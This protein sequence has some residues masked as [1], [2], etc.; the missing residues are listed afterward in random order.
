MAQDISGS[1]ILVNHYSS[2]AV[3]ETSL[4]R[5]EWRLANLYSTRVKYCL[6]DFNLSLILPQGVRRLPSK[7]AHV[8]IS[9]YHPPDIWAGEYDYDPYAF[10]V[11]CMGHV[12]ASRFDV[13]GSRCVLA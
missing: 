13:S 8:G 12:F 10:D 4:A 9:L 5:R 3:A 7:Y 2:D 1:N 6:M 11:A